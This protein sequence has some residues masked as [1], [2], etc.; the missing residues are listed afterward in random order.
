MC[1]YKHLNLFILCLVK[2][3]CYTMPQKVSA[4][5]GLS[6]PGA[7]WH[8]L[9]IQGLALSHDCTAPCREPFRI[10]NLPRRLLPCFS[11]GVAP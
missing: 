10:G 4:T 2:F 11:A 6:S 1:L 8:I 7:G 3:R 5:D 9:E